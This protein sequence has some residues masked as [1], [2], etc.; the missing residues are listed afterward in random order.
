VAIAC[1][2]TKLLTPSNMFKKLSKAREKFATFS[3]LPKKIK[4]SVKIK[5][6][7]ID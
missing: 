7:A 4:R 2:V 3:F 5:N 6:L 1:S